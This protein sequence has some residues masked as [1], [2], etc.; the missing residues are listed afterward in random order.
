[1]P[2]TRQI[3]LNS[4]PQG[5]VTPESFAMREADTPELAPGDVLVRHL[6]MSVDPYMRGLMNEGGVAYAA[7]F[8]IGEPLFGRVIGQV[9]QSRNDKF[10]E[11]DC[12]YGMLDW[13]EWSVAKGGESLRKVDPDLA[14]LS[15]YLGTLGFPGLTAYVG[16]T[17]IGKPREGETVYVSA[18]S[19]AVG[20][21]AGQL[22]RIAGARVVGSAGTDEKVRFIVGECGF[23]DGFNYRLFSIA[24][25]LRLYCGD[26][27]DVNFENV[28][29][30]NLEAVL[31]VA[32]DFARFA[33]CGMISQYNLTETYHV[34]NLNE[35]VSKRLHVQGFVVRD[36]AHLIEP[37]IEETA[38][39]IARG[40]MSVA[41]DI[42]T[43]LENAPQ[44]FIGMLQG[45]NLGKR[46]VHIADRS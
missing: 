30:A 34:R 37:F 31:E 18:A 40:R 20:Q 29:G 28:G 41:E 13:A 8:Q 11:G 46:V 14:P 2:T 7:G 4:R 36:H 23:H 26:G 16:M 5:W 45:D 22:A 38:D 3:V 21:V 25:A 17:L 35:I 12:V 42:V 32:N 33:M 10:R 24:E 27:I 43:G 19:G 15:Y 44:A 6:Y 9:A 39:H 1:M